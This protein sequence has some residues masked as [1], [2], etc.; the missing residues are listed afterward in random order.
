MEQIST[1]SRVD[2]VIVE[3]VRSGHAIIDDCALQ[4]RVCFKRSQAVLFAYTALSKSTP[5]QIHSV[6]TKLKGEETEVNIPD[7]SDRSDDVHLPTQCQ[8]QSSPPCDDLASS[9]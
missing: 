6:L 8:P 1:I 5:L 3:P 2:S 7:C 4:L 9:R